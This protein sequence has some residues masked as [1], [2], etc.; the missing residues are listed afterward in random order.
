MSNSYMAF[1][2]ANRNEF[3]AQHQCCETV[4]SGS[5]YHQLFCSGAS[6]I[7][8]AS[9][10]FLFHP[11]HTHALLFLSSMPSYLPYCLQC[12]LLFFSPPFSS[13]S[14]TYFLPY[15]FFFLLFS[16]LQAPPLISH[17][18]LS[19]PVF[20]P[21]CGFWPMGVCHT[22]GIPHI[23]A[24]QSDSKARLKLKTVC[25]SNCPACALRH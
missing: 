10:L 3:I 5:P 4:S 12:R 16:S 8:L 1:T 21:S 11:K 17:V 22:F 25:R 6:L 23:P 2:G 14:F 24:P 7:P 20:P 15:W 18:P 13:F 19:R 9:F